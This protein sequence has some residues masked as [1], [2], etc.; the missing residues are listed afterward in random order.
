[1]VDC[2]WDFT[3]AVVAVCRWGVADGKEKKGKEYERKVEK[4]K[5]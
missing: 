2:L 1:M 5:I 3:E 4:T